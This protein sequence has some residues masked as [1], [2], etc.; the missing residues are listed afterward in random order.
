MSA[1]IAARASFTSARSVACRASSD[2]TDMWSAT[3][4]GEREARAIR[5]LRCTMSL[6]TWATL[7]KRVRVMASSWDRRS[8]LRRVER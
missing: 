3:P 5:S 8:E 1:S 7:V 2:S 6:S 4:S